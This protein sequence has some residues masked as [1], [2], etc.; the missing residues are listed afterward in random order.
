MISESSQDNTEVSF[1]LFICVDSVLEICSFIAAFRSE[2][3]TD[4]AN[5]GAENLCVFLVGIVTVSEFG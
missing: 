4:H 2:L 1:R 5:A 3:G